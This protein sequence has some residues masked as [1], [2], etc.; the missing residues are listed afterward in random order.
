MVIPIVF[1]S[2]EAIQV[3]ELDLVFRRRE[4]NQSCLFELFLGW[5]ECTSLRERVIVRVIEEV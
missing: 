5:C 1:P 3:S 2:G 4:I